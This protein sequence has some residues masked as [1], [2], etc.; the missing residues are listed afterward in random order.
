MDPEQLA[1]KLRNLTAPFTSGQLVTLAL[2]YEFSRRYG[3]RV[4]RG[5]W[6]LTLAPL[7]L[8]FGPWASL[9]LLA[10][11]LIAG[12]A[13]ERLFTAQEKDQIRHGAAHGLQKLRQLR[14]AGHAKSFVTD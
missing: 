4:D 3:M 14:P 2:T 8:V 1:A 7:C 12:V 5:T 13:T 11:I 6:L 9:C 10:V